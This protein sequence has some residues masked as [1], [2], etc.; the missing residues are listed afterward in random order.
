LLILLLP[1]VTCVWIAVGWQRQGLSPQ[2][3]DEPHYLVM[4]DAIKVDH[5]LDVRK[6]YARDAI[7]KRAYGP[8]DWENHTRTTSRGVFSL[9]SPGLSMYIAIPYEKYGVV[10]V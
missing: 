8:V 10:G 4:A 2:T 7:T 3:G 6:A 1:G 9:H 5:S